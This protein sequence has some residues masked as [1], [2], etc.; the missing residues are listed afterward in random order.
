MRR[1]TADIADRKAEEVLSEEGLRRFLNAFYRWREGAQGPSQLR[2]RSRVLFVC[3]LIRFGGLRLGEAL[4]FD[5]GA[6]LSAGSL[7]IRVRGKW[8]REVPLPR[9]GMKKLLELAES[10][11]L[12]AD[13]GRISQLD[14]GYVRRIFEQRAQ[15]AGLG[16]SLNPSSL[17]HFR[18]GE[19]LRSGVPLPTVERFL[20]KP[21]KHFGAEEQDMP[22]LEEAF[23]SWERERRIG[24]YNS[25]PARVE[26]VEQG[27]FSSRLLLV[28]AGG[29]E[30]RARC[31]NRTVARLGVCPG[32]EVNAGLRMLDLRFAEEEERG[33]NIFAGQM[34]Q[35]V[36]GEDE[37]KATFSVPGGVFL[38]SIFRREDFEARGLK[39]GDSVLLFAAEESLM[40]SLRV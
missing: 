5:D 27:S 22:L 39:P 13:R 36:L 37:V 15:E 10:P 28:G 34:Q 17:R 30:L 11:A 32:L 16:F 24:M 18:E 40:L 25:F 29:L 33:G 26:R 20:G 8:E 21:G 3:L 35:V 38:R 19:L 9:S 2:S 12:A 14:Q 6:D 31:S 4:A 1:D 7:R 23:R